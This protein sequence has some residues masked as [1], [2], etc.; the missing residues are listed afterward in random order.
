[1]VRLGFVTVSASKPLALARSRE[2]KI[3]E[4]EKKLKP[5]LAREGEKPAEQP[6]DSPPVEGSEAIV[7]RLI[8]NG[9]IHDLVDLDAELRGYRINGQ[10][11]DR[12][13]ALL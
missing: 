4:T 10:P 9:V 1:M 5:T 7:E 12:L 3:L 8:R 6:A 13:R 11:A 2:K